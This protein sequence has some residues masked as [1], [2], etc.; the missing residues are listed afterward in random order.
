MYAVGEIGEER[1]DFGWIEDVA[2]GERVWDMRRENTVPA[3]GWEVN[4]LFDGTVSLSPGLYRAVFLTDPRQDYGDWVRNPPFDPAGWGVS[5]FT[6][7]PEAVQ[8]VDP[9]EEQEPF[10]RINRV[11]DSER[12]IARFRVRAPA[13]IAVYA[14]GEMGDEDR[15]DYATITAGPLER[16]VWEMT[17]ERSL[18]RVAA[19]TGAS[20]LFWICRRAYT[21]QPIKRTIRI[22]TPDGRME[23]PIIRNDGVLR[24]SR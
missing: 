4:R 15:Y 2:S 7:M 1:M 5:L 23:N 19:T 9:W 8:P 13:R 14:L 17:P 20:W 21:R 16:V 18:P 6:T 11:G 10:I 3:G 22:R 12:H 24:C